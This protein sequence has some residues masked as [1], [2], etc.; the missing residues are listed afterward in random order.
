MHTNFHILLQQTQEKTLHEQRLN[1]FLKI[2][3]HNLKLLCVPLII[4]QKLW[5]LFMAVEDCSKNTRKRFR[6]IISVQLS[7]HRT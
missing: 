7:I 4:Q 1:I 6:L 3:Q 5:F 2:D